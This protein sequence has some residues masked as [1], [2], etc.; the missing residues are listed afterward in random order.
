M[1]IALNKCDLLSRDERKKTEEEQRERI[2]FAPYVPVG[3]LSAKT[4]RGV[5]E[6]FETMDRVKASYSHRVGTGELNR[7]FD[8]V[9]QTRPPPTSGGR[10][11]PT[12]PVASA[13]PPQPAPPRRSIE[14][15]AAPQP[16][17]QA[18]LPEEPGAHR[19][20]RGLDRA[21]PYSLPDARRP[22]RT[23]SLTCS[24]RGPGGAGSSVLFRHYGPDS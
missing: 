2:P 17:L 21:R 3:R 15:K 14:E 8:D 13:P 22:A 5:K 16:S 1:V 7:F 11:A 6:L 18:G 4:G 24:L 9:L 19:G 20:S 12:T 10:T 23:G